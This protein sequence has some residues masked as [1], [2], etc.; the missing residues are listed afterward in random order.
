MPGAVFDEFQLD[1]D[2]GRP[3][4][5]V[6]FRDAAGEE[7]EAEVDARTGAILKWELD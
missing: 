3:I 2:D 4:Y 6:K 1:E 7:Y 5:E